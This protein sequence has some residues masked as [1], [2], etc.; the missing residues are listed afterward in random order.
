MS[1]PFTYQDPLEPPETLADRTVEL[2]V[3]RDRFGE[4]RNSRLEGPRRYGKTSLLK[5]ALAAADKDGLVPIYVN[6]LGV[7]TATDVAERSGLSQADI[8]RYERGL[9][10]PTRAPQSS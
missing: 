2:A 7:L 5:A 1:S 6:F 9:G 10:N 4:T 8:S 3:L